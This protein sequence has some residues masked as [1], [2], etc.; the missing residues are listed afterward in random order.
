LD[1]GTA[2]GLMAIKAQ[3]WWTCRPIVRAMLEHDEGRR[4][5]LYSDVDGK[6]WTSAKGALTIGVGWNLEAN[7]IPDHIVDALLEH[8]MAT[9]AA[10]LDRLI[11]G[12]ATGHPVRTA[13]LLNWS[14]QHGY[15]RMAKYRNTVPAIARRDWT[16]A[17]AGLNAS[18]WAK[19]TPGRAARVIYAIEHAAV[20]HTY[21]V[22][23]HRAA[24]VAAAVDGAR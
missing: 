8:A 21:P 20:W 23:V 24:R 13:G 9:A 7:G 19:Q 4:N 10:D 12:W 6:T 22:A 17:A 1:D 3:D 15:T 18:M 5:D 16:R 11:P 14:F 2:E